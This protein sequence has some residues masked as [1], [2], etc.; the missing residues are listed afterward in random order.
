MQEP[1]A[2]NEE[3]RFEL[4]R[5]FELFPD[6]VRVTGKGLRI[7][8]F[9][10][11]ISLANFRP[12]PNRLWVRGLLFRVGLWIMFFVLCLAATSAAFGGVESLIAPGFAAVLASVALVGLIMVILNARPIE[13]ARF[14]NDAGVVGLDVGRVGKQTEEFD[15]FVEAVIESIKRAKASASSE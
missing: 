13:F 2:T 6:H 7:S 10:E 8:R 12:Q 1:I 3:A 14:P 5:R 11:T 9:D 15:R 4:R